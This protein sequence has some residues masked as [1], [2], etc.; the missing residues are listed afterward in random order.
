MFLCPGIEDGL[1]N[2]PPSLDVVRTLKQRWIAL[3]AIVDESF[4]AC[5]RWRIEMLSVVELHCNTVHSDGRARDL[6]AEPEGHAFFRLHQNSHIIGCQPLN[7]RI[8]K[9]SERRLLELN[10]DFAAPRSER[11][12]GAQ[13]ERDSGPTPI[14]DHQLERN[15]CFRCG[16][17]CDV[18][19]TTVRYNASTFDCPSTVLSPHDVSPGIISTKRMG[20][21]QDFG[22]F[23]SH[24]LSIKT[25]R[26]L[27]RDQSKEL[28]EVIGHHVSQRTG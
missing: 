12:T 25:G 8:P 20:S 22:L 23:G 18:L 16:R 5:V 2:A 1:H 17:W 3:H 27:H 6:G 24:C 15:V 10:D 11:F 26:W 7:G 13:I 19:A 9:E 14:V 21:L 4:V 28:E